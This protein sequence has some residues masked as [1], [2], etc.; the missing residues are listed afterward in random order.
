[1]ND[2]K[3]L[4][5]SR[6]M[7]II[8]AIKTLD[9]GGQQIV[10]VASEKL[11]LAGTV[12][13]GD[14]RRAIL[15]GV[16]LEVSVSEIMNEGPI[17]VEK[18]TP[19][20][21]IKRLMK[22]NLV[23]K[24]PVV[25]SDRVLEGLYIESEI[26]NDLWK[27]RVAVIMCGGLGKRLGDLTSN[28]PKPLLNIGSKPILETI[29][30]K[31]VKAGCERIYLSVNYK[32]QMIKEYF[33]NGEKWGIEIS[34]LEEDKKLGTAG[35]LSLIEEEI[36]KSIVVMNG[37]ILTNIDFQNFITY[38]EERESM[39]SMCVKEYDFQVPYGVVKLNEDSDIEDIVEK[40]VHNFFVSAGVYLINP[41]VL[42][43]IEKDKRLDMP[44]LYRMV[45]EDDGKVSA[46][47]IREY[48]LDI[49]KLDD[50]KKAQSDFKT[51]FK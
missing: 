43:F 41:S 23:S 18:S 15:R 50:F 25:N 47:P 7:R 31:F 28:C 29:V 49:G 36:E 11:E 22:E 30:D 24:I 3:K 12:S 45:R 35:G 33:G 38:H 26:K 21:E 40:P 46:F 6:D 9:E 32:S 10:F 1:M 19:I 37:D 13:D 4:I 20:T 8:D 39:M 48:W 17:V 51:V 2:W 14:I 27:R 44:E 34:Y 5:V 42:K 16:S